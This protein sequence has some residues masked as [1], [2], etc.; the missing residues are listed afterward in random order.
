MKTRIFTLIMSLFVATMAFA[1]VAE[2][3]GIYYNLE[4]YSK[5]A[6]VTYYY[7][8]APWFDNHIGYS[9]FE[10]IIPSKITYNGEEYSV[11]SI[12]DFAFDGCSSLTSITIPNSVTSIGESAFQSC[13]SLS[14]ITLGNSVTSV[15]KYA[16]SGTLWLNNQ[17]VGC[18]Y[19]NNCLY[20]YKGEMS[21]NTHIDVKEGTTNICYGAFLGCS[22]L[23]SI[24]IP[25]SVISIG[26]SAFLG[27]SSLT[28]IEIPN[29][30]TSIGSSAF[31]SCSSLTSI[32]VDENN[33]NYASIDGVLYDKNK[34]TLICYPGAKT[35]VLIPDSVTS[36]GDFAF[37]GCSSL[38]SITIPNSI[39]HV[40]GG[41]FYNC[42]KL[43][44][45]VLSRAITSIYSLV[46]ITDKEWGIGY[47]IGFFEYCKSLVL[48]TVLAE[49][50]PTIDEYI[51]ENVSR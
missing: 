39:T 20:V 49:N 14:S 51:F 13:S 6:S 4:T 44:S 10:I 33:P 24:T 42:E 40:G 26:S 21:A 47:Y 17:P 31:S 36:I 34:T 11:T 46:E 28:S 30:V 45:V 32:D 7:G 29:S 12:G 38:T 5:R 37:R 15:G 9:Q 23:T 43:E 50:P 19:L 18:V 48:I 35:E 41:L 8:D 3:D 27:C 25:N 1:Y 16:F 22:S 2:I